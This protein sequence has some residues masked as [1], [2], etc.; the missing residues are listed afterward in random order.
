MNAP[1]L[2]KLRQDCLPSIGHGAMVLT[3][4][5]HHSFSNSKGGTKTIVHLPIAE[6]LSFQIGAFT[7]KLNEIKFRDEKKI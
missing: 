7:I 1:H 6:G 2:C 5:L 3:K 4:R